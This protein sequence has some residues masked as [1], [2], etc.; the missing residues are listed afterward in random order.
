M[1]GELTFS[2]LVPGNTWRTFR[3]AD[4]P[5]HGS[6]NGYGPTIAEASGGVRFMPFSGRGRL[7]AILTFRRRTEC[8]TCPA[9]VIDGDT[10]VVAELVVRLHDIDAPNWTRRSGGAVNR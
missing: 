8:L 6:P 2:T 4:Q 5:I 10:I 1:A 9:K 7:I 3:S